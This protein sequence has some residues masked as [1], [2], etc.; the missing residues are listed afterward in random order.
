MRRLVHTAW[1]VQHV[2][3]NCS[4]INWIRIG[5]G[6][7]RRNNAIDDLGSVGFVS[8]SHYKNGVQM[9]EAALLKLN[10]VRVR[11]NDTQYT[12]HQHVVQQCFHL[13]MKH[14]AVQVWSIHPDTIERIFHYFGPRWIGCECKEIIDT[15]IASWQRHCI[16]V[17]FPKVSGAPN[18]R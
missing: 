5:I 7:L 17:Q 6:K 15:T 8:R 18:K 14:A 16:S 3:G 1:T 13:Q 4:K 2:L 11:L 12:V 10:G 9:W